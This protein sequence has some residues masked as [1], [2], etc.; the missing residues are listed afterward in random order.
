ME[1][2]FPP[3]KI[4]LPILVTEAGIFMVSIAVLLKAKRSIVV[5]VDG[6][7]KETRD[8]QDAKAYLLIIVKPSFRV[9]FSRLVELR[10]AY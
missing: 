1:D 3:M 9:T 2:T 7:S 10:K 4:A 8:E 6:R 5:R